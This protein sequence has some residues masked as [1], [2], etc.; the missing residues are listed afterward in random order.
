MFTGF[1]EISDNHFHV[2]IIHHHENFKMELDHINPD[3]VI[4]NEKFM[5]IWALMKNVFNFRSSLYLMI[6]LQVEDKKFSKQKDTFFKNIPVKQ[7]VKN[8]YDIAHGHHIE[9]IILYLCQVWNKNVNN[10]NLTRR[11]MRFF[12]IWSGDRA[13][14][15]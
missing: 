4:I 8:I 12:P 1:F 3:F 7:I 9:K 2:N 14:R 11:S 6:P 15:R 10:F 5:M 13:T